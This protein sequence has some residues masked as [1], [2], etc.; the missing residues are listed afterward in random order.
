MTYPRGAVVPASQVDPDRAVED[1]ALFAELGATRVQL[2]LS[3]PALQP[4]AG[5]LDGDAVER[6][7]A[8]AQAARGAGVELH[9][10]LLDRGVPHWFDD[11][12]GFADD[13]QAGHWWPRYVEACAEAFGDVV[14]GWVPIEHPLAIANRL[15]PDDPRRHGD[16]VANLVVAW[17]DAWRV[18]RGG[19]PVVTTAFGVETVRP[20][21]D[22]VPAAQTA[23]RWDQLRWGVWLEGLRDGVSRIPGRADREIADLQGACD[24]LGIVVRH[25]RDALGHLHRAAEQGLAEKPLAITLLLPDGSDADRETVIERYVRECDE[26][27]SGL[28]LAAASVSPAF[29]DGTSQRGIVTRDRDVKDSAR[30][31]FSGRDT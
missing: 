18:L 12:G 26:A 30:L 23:R 3:W 15:F 16:V 25:E 14:A 27:A 20:A 19:D 8:I 31:F 9:L 28:D 24:V 10:C 4:R 21:D 2:G 11:E 17:R 6:Y 22:S 13:R 7:L 1:V 5:G 29:D